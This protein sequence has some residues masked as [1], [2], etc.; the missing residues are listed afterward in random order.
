MPILEKEKKRECPF[1][2]DL[3]I[4]RVVPFDHRPIVPVKLLTAGEGASVDHVGTVDERMRLR[5]TTLDLLEGGAPRHSHAPLRYAGLQEA[6]PD[7]Q[8]PRWILRV[9]RKND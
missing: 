9:L 7:A 3:S 4:I 2:S 6:S 5:V 1:H 8:Q